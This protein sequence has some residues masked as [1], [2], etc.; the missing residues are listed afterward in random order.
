LEAAD[1][2]GV[3]VVDDDR[4]LSRSVWSGFATSAWAANQTVE[5]GDVDDAARPAR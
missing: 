4:V 5:A 2:A 1:P 3:A